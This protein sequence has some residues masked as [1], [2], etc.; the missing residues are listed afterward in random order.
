MKQENNNE[1]IILGELKKEK[2]SKPLFVIIVFILIIGVCIYLPSIQDY[3]V[4]GNG[5]VP[6]FYR[7]LVKAEES[8][9]DLPINPKT[10]TT[11][12]TAIIDDNLTLIKADTV[13][14]VDN[15][16]LEKITLKNKTISYKITSR[17]EI[18]LNNYFYYLEIYN[19]N[20]TLL[21]TIKLS[22]TSYSVSAIKNINVN[23]A[24]NDSKYYA[25]LFNAQ[26]EL[27]VLNINDLTCKIDNSTF[28]FTF[29]DNLLNNFEIDNQAVDLNDNPFYSVNT[30]SK[31]IKYDMTLKGYDCK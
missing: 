4:H 14:N 11:T 6:E 18:N 21:G 10:T 27:S 26:N 13:L 25:R 19:H 1:P 17:N 23:F 22:G 15:I 30:E 8:E 9:E 7:S 2:S 3:L 24:T 12:T 5:K 16:Y 20:G 31:L 28:K 29:K